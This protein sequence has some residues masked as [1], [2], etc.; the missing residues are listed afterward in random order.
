[1]MKKERGSIHLQLKAAQNQ[2]KQMTINLDM[3]KEERDAIW[4][5]PLRSNAKK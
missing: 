5:M 1:M 4:L 2:Y 3:I